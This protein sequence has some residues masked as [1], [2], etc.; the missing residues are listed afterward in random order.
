MSGFIG[1]GLDAETGV[2][3]ATTDFWGGI[4]EAYDSRYALGRTCSNCGEPIIDKATGNLCVSCNNKKRSKVVQDAM[5]KWLRDVGRKRCEAW[6]ENVEPPV[7]L[8]VIGLTLWT[9]AEREA[10]KRAMRE[11][12]EVTE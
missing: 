4:D 3:R 1:D 7:S 9:Q 11:R 2:Y 10:W 5:H 12:L 6:W 8:R